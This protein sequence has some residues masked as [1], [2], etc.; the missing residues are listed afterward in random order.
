VEHATHTH[1]N[2]PPP[3]PPPPSAMHRLIQCLVEP[4]FFATRW[5]PTRS[6][7]ARP[8][9]PLLCSRYSGARSAQAGDVLMSAHPRESWSLTEWACKPCRAGAHMSRS[10][11]PKS[12]FSVASHCASS[13][14]TQAN[15]ATMLGITEDR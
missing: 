14:A 5:R 11:L 12:M 1:Q 6:G 10:Q 15:S 9:S 4:T 8:R 3:L 13:P 2:P 7:S